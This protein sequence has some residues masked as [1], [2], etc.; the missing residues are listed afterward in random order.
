LCVTDLGLPGFEDLAQQT[1]DALESVRAQRSSGAAH[2]TGS[3]E[4]AGGRV[5]VTAAAGRL[6]SLY[7]HPDAML[8]TSLDLAAAI[9]S[10]VNQALDGQAGE[11][12]AAGHR[13]ETAGLE[14]VDPRALAER[15]AEIQEQGIQQMREIGQAIADVMRQIREQA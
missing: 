15:V 4:A 6:Q 12:S 11:E 8:M 13:G 3:A 2:G 5:Q 9:E 1:R 10:A 14:D 7:L